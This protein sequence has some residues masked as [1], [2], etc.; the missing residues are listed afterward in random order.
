[1]RREPDAPPYWRLSGVYFCYFAFLSAFGPYFT[2]YL[3]AVGFTA[4]EI[5]VA[6]SVAQA[7]RVVLDKK[8]AGCPA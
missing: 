3:D 2:L 1:M 5:G 6:M 8:S 4:A 7:M